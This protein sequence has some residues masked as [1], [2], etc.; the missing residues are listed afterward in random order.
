MSRPN[1]A[2]NPINNLSSIGHGGN[3]AFKQS[4]EQPTISQSL[5]T[6]IDSSNHSRT[7]PLISLLSQILSASQASPFTGL[8]STGFLKFIVG[9]GL[10]VMKSL[11]KVQSLFASIPGMNKGAGRGR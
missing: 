2:R 6:V 4:S 9:D 11:G 3:E 1:F 5:Q 8:E 7:L 10:G